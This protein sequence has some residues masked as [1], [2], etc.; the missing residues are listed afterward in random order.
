MI[1]HGH[2]IRK[3]V[4]RLRSFSIVTLMLYNQSFSLYRW[5]GEDSQS[6]RRS[7]EEHGKNESLRASCDVQTIRE[8]IGSFTEK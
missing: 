4:E 3:V 1:D 2:Q 6:F 5:S 7:Y 8:T